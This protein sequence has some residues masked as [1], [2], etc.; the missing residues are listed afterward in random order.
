MAVRV[1]TLLPN[2]ISS[3]T[4]AIGFSKMNLVAK[5]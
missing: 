2:P 5:L 3:S 4:A 1:I